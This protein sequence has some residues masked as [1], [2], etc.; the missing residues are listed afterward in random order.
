MLTVRRVEPEPALAALPPPVGGG[1]PYGTFFL[2]HHKPLKDN[3]N[4]KLVGL[5]WYKN[6]Y[7]PRC[8]CTGNKAFGEV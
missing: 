8:R 1:I 5:H 4:S 6:Q 2:A 7:K 3:Y